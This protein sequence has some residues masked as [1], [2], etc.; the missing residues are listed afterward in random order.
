MFIDSVKISVKAGKGGDGIVAFRREKYVDKGGPSGGKGG[1]GGDIIFVG[2]SGLTTL[3]DFR[4]TRKIKAESGQNGMSKDMFGKDAKDTYVKVP[5]GTVVYDADTGKILADITKHGEE[6]IIAKGGR[7]G[8]GNGFFATSRNP[9]PDFCEKGFPGEEYN[10]QMELKVLADVGLV[11]FPSVGKSTLISV[12]SEAKPKIASYHFTTIHPNLGVVGVPNGHS[13]VMA[14]LPGL[15]EG[16]HLGHGLGI[17]FLK[18]IERTK[19]IVHIIDMGKTEGR[20]PYDDYLKIRNELSSFREDLLKRPE[21]VVAN[22]MD[23]KGAEENLKEFIEKSKITDVVPISAITKS[24]LTELLYKIDQKLEEVKH[25]K[26]NEVQVDEVV[27]YTFK[28]PEPL[29]TVVKDEDGVFNVSGNYIKKIFD[30]TDFTRDTSIRLFAK[31]LR[32]IGVDDKLRELG[33]Q[34]G[35]TVR[36]LNYEFEFID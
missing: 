25:I 6:A 5:I 34:N 16:A 27:E 9:A 12:V 2:E 17:Q 30:R 21:I 18:H 19:V 1:R 28:K 31:K 15:I 14:D 22:K 4:F 3:L 24:N 20:D 13:F 29:F 23:V 10:L 7:G 33:V 32:D 36:V 26:I 35:D 8:R 11:G